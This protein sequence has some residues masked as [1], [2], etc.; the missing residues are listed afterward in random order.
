MFIVGVL[1]CN[2]IRHQPCPHLRI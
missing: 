2:F 1:L